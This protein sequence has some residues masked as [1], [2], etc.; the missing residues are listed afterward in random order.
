MEALYSLIEARARV[1]AAD[2]VIALTADG[3]QRILQ[4][5]QWFLIE[6]KHG[7]QVTGAQLAAMA[8]N[9]QRVTNF[10][11]DE[12][13]ERAA[14]QREAYLAAKQLARPLFKMYGGKKQFLQFVDEIINIEVLDIDLNAEAAS[15]DLPPT[16]NGPMIDNLVEKWIP[17]YVLKSVEE[18]RQVVMDR[19]ASVMHLVRLHPEKQNANFGEWAANIASYV[20]RNSVHEYR[21]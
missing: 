11:I 3:V 2:D 9:A 4:T 15:L 5:Y 12:V 1:R 7:R 14:R 10:Y 18:D 19:R 17:T 6:S 16:I 20:C 8:Q 21:R 13:V